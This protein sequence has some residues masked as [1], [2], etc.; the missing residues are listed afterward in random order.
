MAEKE[1]DAKDLERKVHDLAK[2]MDKVRSR[3]ADR[4]DVVVDMKHARLSRLEILAGN[5]QT[6]FDDIPEDNDQFEFAL[7]KSDTPRLWIDMTSFVRMVGDGREYE[8]VKDTRM[9]R[10]ILGR[11]A[12]SEQIGELVS[13]YVAERVLERERM[14]EGEWLSLKNMPQAEADTPQT[15]KALARKTISDKERRHDTLRLGLWFL[16][17]LIVGGGFLLAALWFGQFDKIAGWVSGMDI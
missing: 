13:D 14:L 9:G 12:N 16:V 1:M 11:S 10:T 15:K 7:V 2:S 8:F 5:L 3:Q 6:V 4:D 17:G